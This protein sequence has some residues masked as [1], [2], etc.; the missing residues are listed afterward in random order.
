MAE[1]EKPEESRL[2]LMHYHM[3]NVSPT[4]TLSEFINGYYLEHGFGT[5]NKNDF[6]V[7]IFHFLLSNQLKGMSDN[8]ISRKLRIPESKV[9][10][11][12]YEAELKYNK[13]DDSEQ[14][15]KNRLIEMLSNRAYKLKDKNRI[16]FSIRDKAMRLYLNDILE[17]KGSFADS[18]FNGDIVTITAND[19]LLL[20]ANFNEK[21][22]LIVQIKES[23]KVNQESLPQNTSEKFS[24]GMKAVAKD[25]LK[26]I[27]PNLIEWII[28]EDK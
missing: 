8:N 4:T 3:V 6:E 28:N 11:M 16:Q 25:L 14:E 13:V 15:Y 19:L 18:S 23:M 12:R 2:V 20:L 26:D 27:C 21:N 7:F 17:E 24:D 10:R 9:K 1:A 5:M 22:D